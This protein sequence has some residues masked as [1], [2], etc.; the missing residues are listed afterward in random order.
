[1]IRVAW[2]EGNDWGLA[3]QRRSSS[4]TTH[5]QERLEC[6]GEL[7]HRCATQIN[8]GSSLSTI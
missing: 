4:V 8:T 7:P 6:F 2:A 1:M 5:R 3:W